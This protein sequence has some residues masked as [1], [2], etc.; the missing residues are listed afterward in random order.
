MILFLRSLIQG[1][2]IG[3]HGTLTLQKLFDKEYLLAKQQVLQAK[4]DTYKAT[5]EGK[6]KIPQLTP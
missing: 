1:A 6:K 5:Q 3:W 2:N 4:A